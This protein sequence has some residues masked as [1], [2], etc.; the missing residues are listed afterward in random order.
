MPGVRISSISGLPSNTARKRSSTTMAR[1]R[2]GRKRFRISSAGV[3]RTQ[4][5][6]D[7]SRRTATRLPGGRHARTLSTS[8]YSSI[9]ASSTSMTGISSRMGYTR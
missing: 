9:F 4:S 3:V 1:R 7:R 8:P 5:P 2:S 6:S